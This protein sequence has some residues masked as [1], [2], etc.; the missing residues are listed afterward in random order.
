MSTDFFIVDTQN[1]LGLEEI[2][3]WYTRLCHGEESDHP[4]R[5]ISIFLSELHN[6]YPHDTTQYPDK[7]LQDYPWSCSEF[8]CSQNALLLSVAAG[9]PMEVTSFIK[10]LCAKFGL[11]IYDPQTNRITYKRKTWPANE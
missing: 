5:K 6:V 8:E 9:A 11:L 4:G 2:D 10:N 1:L 7:N 3:A